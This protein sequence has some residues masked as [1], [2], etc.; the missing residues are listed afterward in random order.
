MSWNLGLRLNRFSLAWKDKKKS[1]AIPILVLLWLI[2]RIRT[3]ESHWLRK[4][5]FVFLTE[6]VCLPMLAKCYLPSFWWPKSLGEVSCCVVL[7]LKFPS[8]I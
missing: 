4:A 5:A 3:V 2:H 7:K 6:A 1:D 8:A